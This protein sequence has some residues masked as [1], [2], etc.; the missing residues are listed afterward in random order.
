LIS[1]PHKKKILSLGSKH[2]EPVESKNANIF[3]TNLNVM[4]RIQS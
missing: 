3:Y 2:I 4:S 1:S